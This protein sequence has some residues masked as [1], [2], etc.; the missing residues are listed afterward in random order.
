MGKRKAL[1]VAAVLGTTLVAGAVAEAAVK[2]G[3]YAGT[4]SEGGSATLKISGHKLEQLKTQIGYNGKCGQGGGPGYGINVKRVTIKPSGTFSAR[5]TLISMFK[6]VA[7]EPASL[8]GKA[9]G[10]TVTGK[11]VD[12]SPVLLN[13]KCNGYT[14]TFTTKRKTG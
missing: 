1:V 5:I 9:S 12:M 13:A 3:S 14:E 6:G 10:N 8:K 4:N 7:S 2:S 11:I